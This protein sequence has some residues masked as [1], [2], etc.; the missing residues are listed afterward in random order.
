LTV[1]N[2]IPEHME[3]LTAKLTEAG[4]VLE[5]GDDFIK[6]H[7]VK[8]PKP[9]NVQTLPYPGFPTDLHPQMVSLLCTADGQ[10]T[11]TE[12]IHET[13]FQYAEQLMLMGA[14]IRVQG[15]SAIVTGVPRLSGAP[16]KAGDLRAAACLVLAGLVAEG[17]TT[18]SNIHYLDRGYERFV[19]KIEKLG[20][21]VT[22][23]E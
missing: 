14:D 21:H 13:R 7:G 3:S 6:V 23:E 11:I 5:E 18:V 4:I 2:I 20:A 15:G 12:G 16:I 9:I 17:K 22:R 19:E 8:K 1:N 10:S